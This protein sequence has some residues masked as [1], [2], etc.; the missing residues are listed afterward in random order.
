[1]STDMAQMVDALYRQGK[2]HLEARRYADALAAL[3]QA[4][5]MHAGHYKDTDQLIVEAQTVMQ[6]RKWQER[7]SHATNKINLW[8]IGVVVLLVVLALFAL[9]TFLAAPPTT[10]GSA[11]KLASQQRSNMYK[12]VPPMTIDVSKTY[13]A[14]I[15]TAKGNIVVELYPKD[16]PQTVNNFVFLARDGFYNNLTFHRVE[17]G[18]VIQGGDPLGTGSGGPGYTIPAE[19]KA[20]NTK[21]A[22]AMARLPDDV[23]PKRASSG[24]QFYITLAPTPFL[25]SGYTAFGQVTQGTDVVEKIARGDVIQTITIEE[26]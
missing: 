4:R 13:V 1:M 17:P 9:N 26:K 24:S 8:V 12:S 11:A 10:T 2:A 6:K 19:I 23:N 7:P 15:K 25:D 3:R 22:I 14:T 20:K 5:A 18:F 21:G 16:A